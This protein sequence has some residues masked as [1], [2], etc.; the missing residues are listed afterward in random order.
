MWI[1]AHVRVVGER[2]ERRVDDGRGGVAKVRA[3]VASRRAGWMERFRRALLGEDGEYVEERDDAGDADDRGA[4][5]GQLDGGRGAVGVRGRD[6]AAFGLLAAL[7]VMAPRRAGEKN[8]ARSLA[9]PGAS[10][11]SI[12]HARTE[13][14]SATW[15]RTARGGASSAPVAPMATRALKVHASARSASRMPDPIGLREHRVGLLRA[16]RLGDGL[17]KEHV[18]R[19]SAEERL[20]GVEVHG[21]AKKRQGQRPRHVRFHERL[22]PR[23]GGGLSAASGLVYSAATAAPRERRSMVGGPAPEAAEAAMRREV[24]ARERRVPPLESEREAKRR[25][26]LGVVASS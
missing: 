3:D 8:R 22:E 1:G 25:G 7:F 26:A 17:A 21:V 6:D 14:A 16:L 4:V 19:S 23:V 15:V 12:L 11:D 24:C 20:E 18:K 5:S 9:T 13:T 10:Q 2:F